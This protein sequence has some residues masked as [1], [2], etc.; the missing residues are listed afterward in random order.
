MPGSRLSRPWHTMHNG[1][2]HHTPATSSASVPPPKMTTAP[3]CHMCNTCADSRLHAR[4]HN[5]SR[6]KT[7]QHWSTLTEQAFAASPNK[8]FILLPRAKK[9][10][11][12]RP[13][14]NII[15]CIDA[16]GTYVDRESLSAST[17]TTTMEH[18]KSL[19]KRTCYNTKTHQVLVLSR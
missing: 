19:L 4:N 8:D 5:G 2:R 18:L 14:R 12:P 11:P 9:T 13:L 17:A 1:V 15:I 10:R 16:V 7:W 6:S 3:S